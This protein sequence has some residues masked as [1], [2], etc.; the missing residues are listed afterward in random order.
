MILFVRFFI[1]LFIFL[2]IHHWIISIYLFIL[3]YFILYCERSSCSFQSRDSRTDSIFWP[4][5][6]VFLLPQS[7]DEVLKIV[8]RW[9][10]RWA[11]VWPESPAKLPACLNTTGHSLHDGCTLASQPRHSCFGNRIKNGSEIILKATHAK[12]WYCWSEWGAQVHI[13]SVLHTE[14]LT[15][16]FK[17]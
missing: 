17:Y 8:I 15:K 4:C 14:C 10:N 5:V 13:S 7:K 11:E 9:D 1:Y 3:F 16:C 2:Q 6:F 12:S